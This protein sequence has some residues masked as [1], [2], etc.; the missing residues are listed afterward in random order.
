MTDKEPVQIEMTK[1]F[2]INTDIKGNNDGF[3]TEMVLKIKI[4]A[5]NV[6]IP[7]RYGG[8]IRRDL[9]ELIIPKIE[10]SEVK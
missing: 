1:R 9:I 2:D 8:V 10:E 5:K 6:K 4:H 3:I 7:M